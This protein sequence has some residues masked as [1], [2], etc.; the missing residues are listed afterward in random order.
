MLLDQVFVLSEAFDG[1]VGEM[2]QQLA[3]KMGENISVKRFSRIQ[4]GAGS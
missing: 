1:T 4:V 3:V 2:V